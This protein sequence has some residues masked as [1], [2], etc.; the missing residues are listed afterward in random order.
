MALLFGK[1]KVKIFMQQMLQLAE[2][3]VAR[4]RRRSAVF[5]SVSIGRLFVEVGSKQPV[6]MR[7]ASLMG[8]SMKRVRS[9]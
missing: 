1:P 8:L 9:P 6:T 4:F 5:F 2:V 3:I 7:S